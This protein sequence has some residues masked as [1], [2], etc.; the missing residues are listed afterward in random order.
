MLLEKPE[1][2]AFNG[3]PV[4]FSIGV[5]LGGLALGWLVY[6]RNPLQAGQTDPVEK[7]PMFNFLYHRWYWDEL[8]RK[9]FINPLQAIADNYSR[10]VD[11]GVIDRI[12]EGGYAL[13]ARVTQASPSSTAS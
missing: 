12:L 4:L 1:P 2:L 11:K 3:V 10:V 5:A 7:L 8:Y 13:G 9:I 6:A